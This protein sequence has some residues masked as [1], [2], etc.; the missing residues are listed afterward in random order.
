MSV[1]LALAGRAGLHTHHAAI[2]VMKAAVRVYWLT[3]V[4]GVLPDGLKLAEVRTELSLGHCPHLAATADR[5]A[6]FPARRLIAVMMK[7]PSA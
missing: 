1:W 6:A 4:V 3:V 5:P 7:R 2:K